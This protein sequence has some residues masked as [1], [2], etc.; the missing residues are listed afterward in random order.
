[1]CICLYFLYH[2]SSAIVII[3]P[4]NMFFLRH[5]RLHKII[6]EEDGLP[7]GAEVAYYARGQVFMVYFM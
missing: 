2:F 5:Q 1:M 6:F 4:P 7:D 3:C